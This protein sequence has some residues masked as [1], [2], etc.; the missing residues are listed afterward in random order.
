MA[1]DITNRVCVKSHHCAWS[2]VLILFFTHTLDEM[3]E[4]LFTS[5]G[6]PICSRVLHGIVL[7]I[8]CLR[9]LINKLAAGLDLG[10]A[11]SDKPLRL[12]SIMEEGR[13]CQRTKPKC[14][15]AHSVR[16]LPVQDTT[17]NLAGTNILISP[18]TKLYKIIKKRRERLRPAHRS[19]R[20]GYITAPAANHLLFTFASW[21]VRGRCSAKIVPCVLVTCTRLKWLAGYCVPLAMIKNIPEYQLSDLLKMLL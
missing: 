3:I 5:P 10:K 11:D 19:L 20:T 18:P 1:H 14:C 9:G 4:L 7:D 15:W 16:T 13:R 8:N 21:R 2:G 12:Y 6:Q 17:V